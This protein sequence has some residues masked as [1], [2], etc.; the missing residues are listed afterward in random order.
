MRLAGEEYIRLFGL[1]KGWVWRLDALDPVEHDS[2]QL[3]SYVSQIK[4]PIRTIGRLELSERHWVSLEALVCPLAGKTAADGTPEP[5]RIL[6]CV[7]GI[8]DE[9]AAELP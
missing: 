1:K 2:A 3:L 4:Q 5:G 8:T 9:Q 6:G 7:A